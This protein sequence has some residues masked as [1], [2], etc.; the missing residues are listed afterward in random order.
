MEPVS[1][2]EGL[3]SGQATHEGM[4]GKHN[5]DYFGV[6]AWKVD[7]RLNQTLIQRGDLQ[8]GVVADGVGGQIAGEV[9]SRMTVNAIQDYFDKQER[10]DDIGDHL[11]KAILVANKAVYEA[12]QQNA[13][14]HGMG[15]TVAAVALVDGRLHTAHVGDSRIYLLRNGSLRQL[16]IDHTWAQE[17]IEAGLLTREQARNHPNRNVI[18]RHI[19]GSLQVEVDHRLVLEPDQPAAVALANQG[20]AVGAGDTLLICSDGLTDM[21]DDAAVLESLQAHFD[22]L[23][24]AAQELI[25]KA[26]Q[27]GG[28]DNITV[29]IMQAPAAPPATT[30]KGASG[31]QRIRLMLRGVVVLLVAIALAIALFLVFG[32]A[33]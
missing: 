17:A 32:R 9:A 21:I 25:D 18:R 23:T 1:I 19:G 20:M 30:T 3:N 31:G 8:L 4:S 15:T 5:E 13:D 2:S 16:S 22:D 14:Y 29:V 27:A 7:E 26:N 12:S 28:R 11:E 24:V 6:F 33:L 10:V